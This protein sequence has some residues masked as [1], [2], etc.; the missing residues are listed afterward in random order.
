MKIKI[1]VFSKR[2]GLSTGFED[3]LK[4]MIMEKNPGIAALDIEEGVRISVSCFSELRLPLKRTS[5]TPCA[6]T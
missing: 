3:Y 5:L 4:G 6:L 2:R 1:I